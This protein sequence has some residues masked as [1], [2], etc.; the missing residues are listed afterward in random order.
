MQDF[1]IKLKWQVSIGRFFDRSS[2]ITGMLTL[3]IKYVNI[4]LNK[5]R[6]LRSEITDIPFTYPVRRIVYVV[7]FE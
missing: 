2:S 6:F 7:L 1:Q 3:V 4:S 5:L